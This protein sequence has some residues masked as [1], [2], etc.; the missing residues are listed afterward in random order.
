MG[1]PF[2]LLRILVV[3]AAVALLAPSQAQSDRGASHHQS[4]PGSQA[5][6]GPAQALSNR[7]GVWPVS[8]G[9]SSA[10]K[11]DRRFH[12][13]EPSGSVAARLKEVCGVEHV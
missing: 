2:A 5:S 11:S 8:T 4:A 6:S 1:T 12:A 7:L 9:I 3:A 13:K 10:N